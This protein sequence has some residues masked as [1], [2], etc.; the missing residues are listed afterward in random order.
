MRTIYLLYGVVSAGVLV[1]AIN[2]YKGNL[3]IQGSPIDC[4][5]V[6]DQTVS[7]RSQ[8]EECMR[9]VE[10]QSQMVNAI[11]NDLRK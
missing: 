8:L 5:K 11:A 4:L 1:T 2:L 10:A 6:A 7:A 3:D 9:P